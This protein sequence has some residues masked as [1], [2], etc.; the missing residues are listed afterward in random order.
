MLDGSHKK[1]VTERREEN[2]L[3]NETQNYDNLKIGLKC[4]NHYLLKYRDI[5]LSAFVG[6]FVL[7]DNYK[8]FIL[9]VRQCT[10]IDDSKHMFSE[11]E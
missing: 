3:M 8:L 7:G 1:Y 9:L 11:K 5:I 4:W 6:D 2:V 10:L